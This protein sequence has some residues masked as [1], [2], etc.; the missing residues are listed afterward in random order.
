MSSSKYWSLNSIG[1]HGRK[2][3]V[4]RKVRAF[5]QR[6]IRHHIEDYGMPREQAVAV[7]Y[8]EAREKF[9]IPLRPKR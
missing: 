4:P 6:H 9:K 5:M 1:K 8:A 3:K 7:S 2:L